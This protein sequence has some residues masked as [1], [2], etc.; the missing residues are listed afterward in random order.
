MVFDERSAPDEVQDEKPLDLAETS[1]LNKILHQGLEEA[2]GDRVEVNL[3]NDPRS[4]LYSLQTFESLELKK[5]LID[6]IYELGFEQPSKIQEAAL[7]LL[8]GSPPKDILAQSQSGTGKTAAFLL[9]MLHRVDAE[10]PVPQCICLAPTF[11]LALQ[12][13]EVAR[14]M[15]KY[16]PAVKVRV[17]VKGELATPTTRVDEQVIIATPG[18]LSDFL[19]KFRLI[20]A[21]HIICF[22]CDEADIMLMQQGYRDTTIR[23]HNEIIQNNPAVQCML[24][25]ATFTDE[26]TLFAESLVPDMASITLR[27][28]D[29]SLPNIK[30]FMIK[31]RSR[32]EKYNAIM[33]L[34]NMLSIASSI[35]FCYTRSSANWLTIQI[36]KTGRK[37][38]MLHGEMTAEQRTEA[39]QEFRDG[40]FRVLITTNVCA[41]GLDIPQ[42]KMV[43]NYDPPVTFEQVPQPDYDTYLHRI[44]RTGRFGKKG[45]AVNLVDNEKAIRCVKAFEEHFGRAIEE[46]EFNDYERLDTIDKET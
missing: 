3:R 41:R 31:C 17:L 2:E 18:K 10:K 20:D 42:V 7:P 25:S 9:T 33:N 23:I 28:S 22:V 27:R 4:P 13:G 37:V 34:Y 6:A 29:Q 43:C 5:P 24:F 1:R 11:E 44:G 35:I 19:F 39:V 46:L 30:Q 21:K 38:G 16:M 14:K 15:A 26:V 40:K 32:E 8:L 12:I 36:R 45:I